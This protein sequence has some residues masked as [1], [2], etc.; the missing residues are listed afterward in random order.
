MPSK[1]GVRIRQPNPDA[2]QSPSST[3]RSS[4]SQVRYSMTTHI[5]RSARQRPGSTGESAAATISHSG[6]LTQTGRS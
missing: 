3:T 5:R 2:S 1:Y 4:D 6:R